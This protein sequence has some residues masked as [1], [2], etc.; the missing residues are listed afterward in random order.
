MKNRDSS[1]RAVMGMVDP[2]G[3]VKRVVFIKNTRVE[4][5]FFEGE[6]FG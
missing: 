5:W 1:K 6:C 2:F 4:E 3:D